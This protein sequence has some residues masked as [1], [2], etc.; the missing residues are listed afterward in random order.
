M[1]SLP[2]YGPLLLTR[3]LQSQRKYFEHNQKGT[4]QLTYLALCGHLG[5]PKE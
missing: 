3:H 5:C 2:H 1:E 4:V